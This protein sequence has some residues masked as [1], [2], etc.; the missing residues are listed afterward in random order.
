L[1]ATTSQLDALRRHTVVVADTSDFA[2]LARYGARDATTNPTL[3]LK[4]A[5]QPQYGE[6]LDAALRD[7]PHGGRSEAA[8]IDE[9]LETVLVAFGRAILEVVPGRVSTETPAHLSFRFDGLVDSGRRLIARYEA[10]GI[11]RERVL[12]KVASTWEGIQAARQLESEGIHCN[13][14]L[15]FSLAQAVACAE[16]GIT[17]ISPFV[18]RILDW[19][20]AHAPEALEP[21]PGVQSVEGIW[22]YFKAHGHATEVMGASFRS[23]AQVLALAGCDLLTISPALLD[24]LAATPGE[25]ACRLDA[26]RLPTAPARLAV[27]EASFRW[28]MNED[29]MASDKLAEGLRLFHADGLKLAALLR[30]RAAA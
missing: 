6:I 29:R 3:V 18:G 25:V 14:T 1:T 27:D 21:D 19:Y 26:A 23:T 30:E 10:L 13:L 2:Q 15:L 24:E 7:T 5:S 16:A 8:W 20:K 12:I 22:Q 4:A 28:A 9:V 11:P 17:L